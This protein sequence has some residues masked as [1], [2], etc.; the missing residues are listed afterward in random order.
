LANAVGA[1][2]WF[3]TTSG[4]FFANVQNPSE[5]LAVS[6]EPADIDYS[7]FFEFIIEQADDALPR[8]IVQ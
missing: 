7:S 4:C 8:L 3:K 6:V 2:I 1:D 5:E